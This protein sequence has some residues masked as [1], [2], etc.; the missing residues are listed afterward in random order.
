HD[1]E[2]DILLKKRRDKLAA[3]RFSKR[4]LSACA[5]APKKIFTNQLGSYRAAK[6]DMPK[7]TNVKYVCVKAEACL[8]TLNRHLL[9]ASLYRKR[10]RPSS[11][12]VRVVDDGDSRSYRM[13]STR[14]V[15]G[16]D[17]A[18]FHGSSSSIRLAGWSAMRS[19]T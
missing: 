14:A 17:G 1:I 13:G 5:E 3:K 12:V 7:R 4:V 8:N 15:D 18:T 2:L 6:A 11:T 9:R 10:K 16:S 19:S